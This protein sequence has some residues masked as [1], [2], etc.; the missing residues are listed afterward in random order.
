MMD[1]LNVYEDDLYSVDVIDCCDDDEYTRI[2][3]KSTEREC[4]KIKVH[5]ATSIKHIINKTRLKQRSDYVLSVDLIMRN[6]MEKMPSVLNSMQLLLLN[7]E[8]N[9]LIN[10]V[11]SSNT[12]N[13][14]DIMH[15]NSNMSVTSVLNTASLLRSTYKNVNFTFTVYHDLEEEDMAES[16]CS[17]DSVFSKVTVL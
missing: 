5:F 14:T 6:K 13:Y 12:T 1:G 16:I 10:K 17:H 11:I 4:K 15:I 3:C 7:Y 9:K 8:V 2:G